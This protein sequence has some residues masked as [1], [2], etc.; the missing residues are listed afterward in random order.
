MR[1]RAAK[2][3][4]SFTFNLYFLVFNVKY[5]TY[6]ECKVKINITF[7]EVESRAQMMLEE[8]AGKGLRPRLDLGAGVCPKALLPEEQR[9][10]DFPWK[11]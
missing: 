6:R 1:S 5:V 8:L 9:N 3:T 2:R 10:L 4:R 7:N 11:K